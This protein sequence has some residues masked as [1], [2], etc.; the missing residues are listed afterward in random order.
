MSKYIEPHIFFKL[1]GSFMSVKFFSFFHGST[2]Y[3]EFFSLQ[4]QIGTLESDPDQDPVRG[5]QCM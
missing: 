2:I 1:K 5:P 4:R 3:A